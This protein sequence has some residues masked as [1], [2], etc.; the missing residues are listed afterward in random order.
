M[1]SEAEEFAEADKKVKGKVDARNKLETYVYQIKS[2]VDDKLK[3][4]VPISPAY[5]PPARPHLSCRPLAAK[6]AGALAQ[7]APL[8]QFACCTL[9]ILFKWLANK[10]AESLACPGERRSARRTRRR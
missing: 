10:V 3:D 9:W 1:V 8:S 6:T 7:V 5:L 2:S 4:K